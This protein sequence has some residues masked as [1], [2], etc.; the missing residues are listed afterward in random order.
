MVVQLA[1]PANW[2]QQGYLPEHSFAGAVTPLQQL[3]RKQCDGC[4]ASLLHMLSIPVERNSTGS[5]IIS[6]L[7]CIRKDC[8]LKQW[9]AYR[10]VSA[11]V[12]ADDGENNT[13]TQ[14]ITAYNGYVLFT[15]S[16]PAA[17]SGEFSKQ[18][19]NVE[20]LSTAF[21]T[22]RAENSTTDT[23]FANA[24]E[25]E[26]L[27]SLGDG[28][29][30]AFE[31]LST[32]AQVHSDTGKK[33]KGKKSESKTNPKV[34]IPCTDV[35]IESL[36]E[37]PHLPVFEL[38]LVDEPKKQETPVTAESSEVLSSRRSE[39]P[40]QIAYT[41]AT[42]PGVQEER[43]KSSWESEPYERANQAYKFTKTISRRPDQVARLLNGNSFA[44]VG[45]Y[46]KQTQVCRSCGH[47][48]APM[49]QVVSP[50]IT[51]IMEAYTEPEVGE[52]QA[53]DAQGWVQLEHIMDEDVSCA[54]VFD[55]CDCSKMHQAGNY[56]DSS[57][58]ELLHVT[59]EREADE[60]FSAHCV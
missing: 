19:N 12:S 9:V 60:V 1:V 14:E 20:A 48:T 44:A 32:T 58:A 3:R 42:Q 52:D 40:D 49:L 56:Q 13:D 51:A 41:Q 36:S 10:W 4:A 34:R 57:G 43:G 55:S 24:T 11:A 15:E 2:L 28:I 54:T 7:A 17:C 37:I 47:S 33:R 26:S 16:L 46:A 39:L 45:K 38:K 50:F 35:R 31:G 25:Q 6:V 59:V 8:A 5:V 22:E 18:H 27:Q 53:E 29:A 30:A 21:S 23:V